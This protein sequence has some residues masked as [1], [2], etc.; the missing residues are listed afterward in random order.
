MIMWLLV[1]FFNP[2]KFMREGRNNMYICAKW[3]MDE[4]KK[5]EINFL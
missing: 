4:R 3:E 5:S 1:L 2:L